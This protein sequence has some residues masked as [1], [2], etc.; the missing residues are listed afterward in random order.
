MSHNTQTLLVSAPRF[1][2]LKPLTQNYYT[3]RNR[4]VNKTLARQQWLRLIRILGTNGIVIKK[5]DPRPKIA[6]MVFSSQVGF[7]INNCIILANHLDGN[8]QTHLRQIAYSE[9]FKKH[10][11]QIIEMPYFFSGSSDIVYSHNKNNLWIGYDQ[12]TSLKACYYLTE[13]LSTTNQ[14]IRILKLINPRFYHLDLCFCVFG[15]NYVLVYP[16]AFDTDSYQLILS[17]FG[18]DQVITVSRDEAEDLVANSLFIKDITGKTNGY[19]IGQKISN[20]LKHIISNL[21][22]H[23]IEIPLSEFI[24]GGG[25]AKSLILEI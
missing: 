15:E 21:G 2:D 4:S 22:Y 5:I 23:C 25:S 19:L 14:A 10:G 3:K 9:Y 17:S 24:I 18:Q 16:E 11:Y 6:N 7:Q 12:T 1:Y 8:L 13:I 20:R